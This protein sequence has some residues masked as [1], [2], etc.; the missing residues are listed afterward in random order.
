MFVENNWCSTIIIAK[1]LKEYL[2]LFFTKSTSEKI[3][4]L[5]ENFETA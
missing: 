5:L 4:Y 1:T 2:H 3:Q